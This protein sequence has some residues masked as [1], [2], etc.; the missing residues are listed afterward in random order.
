MLNKNTY[1]KKIKDCYNTTYFELELLQNNCNPLVQ[2]NCNGLKKRL[3][4]L[5]RELNKYQ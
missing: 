3:D 2:N 1:L 5:I 4:Y